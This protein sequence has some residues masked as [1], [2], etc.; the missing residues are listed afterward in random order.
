MN[1]TMEQIGMFKALAGLVITTGIITVVGI[2][3]KLCVD[4]IDIEVLKK[5][6]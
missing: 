4:K 6:I 5:I 2:S 1:L 3:I